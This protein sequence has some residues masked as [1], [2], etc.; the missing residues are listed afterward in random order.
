MEKRMGYEVDR[1]ME[2]NR[3]VAEST[4][5]QISKSAKEGGKSSQYCFR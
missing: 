2:S 3:D 1:L 4:M 5:E